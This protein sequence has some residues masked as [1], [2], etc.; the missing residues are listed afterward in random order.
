MD[1]RRL[2]LQ[3][4][5][6][7][8]RVLH[9]EERDYLEVAGARVGKGVGHVGRDHQRVLGAYLPDVVSQPGLG[10]ALQDNDEL[11]GLVSVQGRAR[12]D[13]DDAVGDAAARRAV[14]LPRDVPLAIVGPPGCF[15]GVVVVDNRH[16]SILPTEL[17]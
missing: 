5:R 2:A 4:R 15:G 1:L 9:R 6:V 3:K 13:S 16:F 10:R 14:A 17:S 11:V 8:E 12:S 7:V